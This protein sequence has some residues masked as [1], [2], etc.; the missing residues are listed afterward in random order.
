[1]QTHSAYFFNPAFMKRHVSFLLLIL[2]LFK[3]TTAQYYLKEVTQL[4]KFQARHMEYFPDTKDWIMSDGYNVFKVSKDFNDATL[5]FNTYPA[6]QYEVERLPNKNIFCRHFEHLKWPP[7][8]YPMREKFLDSSAVYII[9]DTLKKINRLSPSTYLRIRKPGNEGMF[10]GW[11][12]NNCFFWGDDSVKICNNGIIEIERE[13]NGR[14]SVY[15]TIETKG[16]ITAFDMSADGKYTMV[17]MKDSAWYFI[18]NAD[19][20]K[21]LRIPITEKK[22]VSAF[23]FDEARKQVWVEEGDWRGLE[24]LVLY[25]YS[26]GTPQ[27]LKEITSDQ[28]GLKGKYDA[29]FAFDFQQQILY[30][31]SGLSFLIQFDLTGQ[32]VTQDFFWQLQPWSITNINHIYINKAD[33]LLYLSAQKYDSANTGANNYLFRLQMDSIKYRV[34][35]PK[36]S[37]DKNQLY[38][39]GLQTAV[40]RVPASS[41][42]NT[43]KLS[44]AVNDLALMPYEGNEY[45]LYQIRSGNMIKSFQAKNMDDV[46]IKNRFR[47]TNC[48]T[49]SPDGK[50]IFEWLLKAGIASGI[51]DTL[52]MVMTDISTGNIQRKKIVLSQ[53]E[54]KEIEHF[55][56][57]EAGRPVFVQKENG[58]YPAMIISAFYLDSAMQINQLV[59]YELPDPGI[60]YSAWMIPGTK[61][62]LI[63]TGT[64]DARGVE[65]YSLL[66]AGNKEPKFIV[67]TTEP[68]DLKLNRSGFLLTDKN[69]L[70]WY[71]VNGGMKHTTT[72]ELKEYSIHQ[73]ADFTPNLY[74][75]QDK[76]KNVCRLNLLTGEI[77]PIKSKSNPTSRFKVSPDEKLLVSVSDE[78]GTWQ[79]EKDEMYK[80]YQLKQEKDFVNH[81]QLRGKYL[82]GDGRVWNLQNGFLIQAELN[83]IEIA[84]DSQYIRLAR[85][86]DII[87][88]TGYDL[89]FKSQYELK[90]HKK[91]FSKN[92]TVNTDLDKY[93]RQY[94]EQLFL[95][96][97]NFGK[98]GFNSIYEIPFNETY[99]SRL[100]T[101]SA[102]QYALIVKETNT[103]YLNSETTP[104]D[105]I[106]FLDMETGKYQKKWFG[107]IAALKQV[108]KNGDFIFYLLNKETGIYQLYKAGNDGIKNIETKV[109][110]SADSLSGFAI[111][112][113]QTIVYTT[114]IG[115]E[116][117]NVQTSEKEPVNYVYASGNRLL[118]K[119][120]YYDN[121]EKALYQ[122]YG[123]G[124]IL[125]VVN[126]KVVEFVKAMPSAE[127]IVGVE[128]N[129]VLTMDKLGNYYFI[130]KNTL[131]TD[132]TLFTWKTK[133][134]S[135]RK[136]LWLTK[137]NYYMATPGVESNIHFVQNS[138]VIPL[139]QGDLVFNRPD[140]VMEV[141]GAPKTE[142]DFYNQLYQI[143]Q[144]KY[145]I[146]GNNI[147]TPKPVQLTVTS[148]PAL[149]KLQLKVDAAATEKITKLQ[150]VV[151]GC[152]LAIQLTKGTNT[153][154]IQQ[155]ISVPLN[156]GQNTIYTWAEDEKGNR[157]RFDERKIMGEFAD[158]GNWYFVGI[159]VS[160][161]KDS[162]NNLKYAD[163]DIRDIARLL[164]RQYPE[165][166]IDTLLNEEA[167]AANIK[168]AADKLSKTTADDKVLV[169]FSGHG[170]LDEKN[171]FWFATHDMDFN[172]PEQRGFSMASISAMLEN[173]PAR[174]R[175]I[176]LDAC[177]SGDV[178][179]GTSQNPVSPE[180]DSV[181]K[182]TE[183]DIKGIILSAT[184]HSN[185]SSSQLLKSM[186]LVFTD[187]LSNT[188]INLIA[189][190]SGTEYALEGKDW[191]NG[192]FTY[193][194]INGWSTY[195]ALHYR[196]LKEYIQQTVL[197]KTRGAQTPNTVMENGEIDWWLIPK[198]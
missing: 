128:G 169:A 75:V 27:K 3:T 119:Y 181:T 147:Q 92:I 74:L 13:N 122:L 83:N 88:N 133:N 90:P 132:L 111:V 52:Q 134:Y 100:Y 7:L 185:Q 163:K 80:L 68:V 155:A 4:G 64:L 182:K 24:K 11:G 82:V 135:D 25:D 180:N 159:G 40:N 151:N 61:N 16:K 65:K 18:P 60:V 85:P 33:N 158:T 120:L 84:N 171:K 45:L 187:Q 47:E 50:Y 34:V 71:D 26:S 57:D 101:Y 196:D 140:K 168:K 117:L 98:E 69:K 28:L 70:T 124:A 115:I 78:I 72:L 170:L 86:Y 38:A 152:P 130:N 2:A 136:Y 167:T 53:A 89:N 193:A 162:T 143:R 102:K 131:E 137:E 96:D 103:G 105:S 73:L 150:V 114:G 95:V 1:M 197:S 19:P 42:N 58:V 9:G 127:G 164:K 43:D 126:K 22:Q 81:S 166:T 55:L 36:K 56:W 125:K 183:T 107:K 29:L 10:I 99:F 108:Q 6:Y 148:S 145:T 51:A 106:V 67:S 175:M 192:V 35:T 21:F 41:Y 161:Y 160:G 153:G 94:A 189:A 178:A 20:E 63:K 15:I 174:Y 179:E 62:I 112:D 37:L 79:L 129:F 66:V 109:K 157:S 5:L 12:E 14:D 8:G 44:L 54:N 186:Q 173:I 198:K 91:L 104:V 149:G 165:I 190:S 23:Y 191:S 31:K 32:S 113:E 156:A 46:N 59:K 172:K 116:F 177:H 188:G 77:K 17:G 184:E 144:K 118:G 146:A 121:E 97:Q 176:T 139:K 39:A 123:D 138:E 195:D 49:I 87:E 30:V 76:S 154:Q 48:V 194:L 142:I 110:L 141:L 93:R